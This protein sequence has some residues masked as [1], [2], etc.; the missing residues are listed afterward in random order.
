VYSR[1]TGRLDRRHRADERQ[2]EA[3]AKLRQHQCRR[4]VARDDHDIRMMRV[5]QR[6]HQRG[7][8]LDQRRFGAAVVRKERVVGGI[9]NARIRP[10]RSDLAVD[11]DAA[12][13]GIK[14]KD[15][16]RVRHTR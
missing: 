7:D 3:Q 10:R 5:D 6:R 1:A 4:G 16:R 9:D 15:R 8:A 12:Q 14:H 11:G 2:R 13:P